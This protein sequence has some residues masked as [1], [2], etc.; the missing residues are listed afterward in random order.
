MA[1]DTYGSAAATRASHREQ[2]FDA[3]RKALGLGD[4]KGDTGL[5]LDYIDAV[6]PGHTADEVITLTLEQLRREYGTTG[7]MNPP[8]NWTAAGWRKRTHTPGPWTVEPSDSGDPSVG[9]APTPPVVFT[10]IPNREE[11][12]IDIAVVGSTIYDNTEEGHPQSWGDPDANARLIAAAPELLAA[13]QRAV[14][15][16]DAEGIMYGNC[17]DEPLD[18][19]EAARSAIE[20]A[21]GR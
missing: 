1:I 12:H 2:C 13:L 14:E 18:V 3:V 21:E 9:L 6:A 11:R 8:V 19:L 16:L 20:K 10:C 15:V 4:T 7:T 5:W 17:D